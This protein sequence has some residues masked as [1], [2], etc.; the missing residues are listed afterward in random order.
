MNQSGQSFRYKTLE[1]TQKDK[2]FPFFLIL[3]IFKLAETGS[4]WPAYLHLQLGVVSQVNQQAVK[5]SQALGVSP[6]PGTPG[7][8]TEDL[9]VVRKGGWKK[10]RKGLKGQNAGQQIGLQVQCENSHR[11]GVSERST[12]SR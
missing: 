6:S 7:M 2:V 4:Y 5:G 1:H 11:E 12:C 3:L 8:E 10:P 9:L